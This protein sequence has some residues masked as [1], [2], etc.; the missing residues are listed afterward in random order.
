MLLVCHGSRI[1][2]G[3]CIL[4]EVSNMDIPVV[5]T[6][7]FKNI[8]YLYVMVVELLVVSVYSAVLIP[9][10]S[11]FFIEVKPQILFHPRALQFECE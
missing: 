9:L 10:L 8:C 7:N 6:K 2:T 3:F 5:N 4:Y 11:F 1:L